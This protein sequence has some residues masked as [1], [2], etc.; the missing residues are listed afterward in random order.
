MTA[1]RMSALSW[2]ALDL[3][4][5]ELPAQLL[6]EQGV[7]GKEHGSPAD[8]HWLAMTSGLAAPAN[9]IE[10]E[11]LLGLEDA[12]EPR[13]TL[14]RSVGDVSYAVSYYPSLSIDAAGRRGFIEK[15]LL[16]WKRP[17]E[18]P[19]AIGT[20]LLL[21]AVAQLDSSTWWDRRPE[22]RWSE[23]DDHEIALPVA[24]PVAVSLPAIEEAIANGLSALRA[25]I[26]EDALAEFYAA[27]LA[28]GRAVSL[29]G[30][31]S[32]LPPAAVAALLLPLPR[33]V[34]DHLSIAG[35][36]PSSRSTDA[37]ELQRCWNAILGG[38]TTVPSSEVSTAELLE[39]ARTMANA[40]FAADAL[41]ELRS[42]AH[43]SPDPSRKIDL[44]L[45]G[46]SAAGKTV[47]LAKL[48]IDQPHD[49]SAW[50]VF[51]TNKAI[52]FFNAM[53]DRIHDNNRF[54]QATA[55]G[56]I[57]QIEYDLKHASGAK[58]SLHMEDRPG[59]ESEQLPDQESGEPS[60]K[61]RLGTADGLVLLFD[62]IADESSLNS[63]VWNTL[64]RLYLA[65]GRVAEK[66]ERPIAVCVSKADLF[67]RKADDFRRALDTPHEFVKEWIPQSVLKALDARCANYRLF[68]VSA[69]GVRVRHGVVEPVV[70]F[71]EALEPRLC[72]DGRT[73]NL[74][75]PFSWLLQELA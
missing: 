18:V 44:T 25:A 68:P 67:V 7:W 75:A 29:K 20:L 42:A 13:A 59:R 64:D 72:P 8:F 11:L 22:V 33:R 23:E 16:E 73:F 56:H 36:L 38:A 54:P 37:A 60:L 21:S 19:A 45:W 3:G 12:A 53:R 55:A 31:D 69:A 57:E 30:L 6:V 14:W 34:A 32:P 66:D 43:G 2:P 9:H 65:S 1:I 26:T 58:F 71:D 47:L 48:Y 70:F 10:R 49:D 5:H 28:G 61:N 40:M 27:L 17:P 41:P 39:Q 15:Q 62:T 52:D 63:R 51:P 46:P 24:A 50:G 4:G 74:M 35:W